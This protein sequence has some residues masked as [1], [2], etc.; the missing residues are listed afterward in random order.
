MDGIQ[1]EENIAKS[2]GWYFQGLKPNQEFHLELAQLYFKT[3]M[4]E[5]LFLYLLCLT[6]WPGAS[7]AGIL[8]LFHYC[9]L[10]V[11]LVDNLRI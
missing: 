10:G 2:Q 11:F 9:M 5:W 7:I 6:L 1:Y 4:D 3:A 8:F